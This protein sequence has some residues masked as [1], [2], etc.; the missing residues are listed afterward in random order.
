MIFGHLGVPCNTRTSLRQGGF[1]LQPSWRSGGSVVGFA[2]EKRKVG[3][4]GGGNT[5]G[6]HAGIMLCIHSYRDTQ[7]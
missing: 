5:V 1:N 6:K 2:S 7:I 3:G 4:E